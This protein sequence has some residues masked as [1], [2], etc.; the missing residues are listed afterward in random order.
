MSTTLPI[1]ES[2]IL[3]A[4]GIITGFVG[5][6]LTFCLKS[7]CSEIRCCCVYCKRD[8][9]PAAE[10]NAIEDIIIEPQ[11]VRPVRPLTSES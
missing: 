3:T 7:R 6:T 10:I 9:I 11:T 2:F 4:F 1:S 5:A 8:V